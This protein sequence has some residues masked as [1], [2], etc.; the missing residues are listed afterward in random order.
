MKILPKNF[1][2]I[3]IFLSFTSFSY[4]LELN[5]KLSGSL[6]YFNLN[7]INL[8]LQSREQLIRKSADFY[9]DWVFKEG[10]I[11]D[12]H[13]GTYFEGEFLLF[14]S[15]RIAA[16]ISTGY[17]YGD[18]SEK[19][20]SMF[21]SRKSDTYIFMDPITINAFPLNVA[22]YYFFP[23]QNKL[24]LFVKEGAGLLWTKFVERK[25]TKK[26]P[27]NKF[28]FLL[29]QKATS[30]GK[31][32]FS[33]IGLVYEAEEGIHFFIEGQFRLAKISN[34]QGELKGG[35]KAT[36]Y[37]FEEYDSDLD[38]WESKNQLFQEKPSG[39][40]FRSVEKTVIDLSGISLILGFSFKF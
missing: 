3:I 5:L 1:L 8:S 31:S 7:H 20:T 38:F 19:K 17:L 16:G 35:E 10:Q 9:Q 34:F 12:F 13:L 23:I 22:A 32:F 15:P 30:L 18:I 11:K 33:S 21:I 14:F 28:T 24:K 27:A 4:S 25:E 39:E 29:L 40:T 2:L 36:L 6:N 26:M 37:Y